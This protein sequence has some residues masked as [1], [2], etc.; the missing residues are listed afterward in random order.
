M[1]KFAIISLKDND[2]I[3]KEYFEAKFTEKKLKKQFKCK[4]V[5]EIPLYALNLPSLS[6]K[7]DIEEYDLREFIFA[8]RSINFIDFRDNGYSKKNLKKIFAFSDDA[9]ETTF[10][11]DKLS[12]DI[13][14]DLFELNNDNKDKFIEDILSIERSSEKIKLLVEAKDLC[15]SL[16]NVEGDLNM[17]FLYR[18]YD[19][20]IE[21]EIDELESTI[22]TKINNIK[23][24]SSKM[25]N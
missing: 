4:E 14:I 18:N 8:I 12:D 16:S 13:K 2:S 11:F 20:E 3:T 7:M 17:T 25:W 23:I 6:N 1:T 21:D 24:F 5:I 9:L 19:E 10:A 22:D 15:D